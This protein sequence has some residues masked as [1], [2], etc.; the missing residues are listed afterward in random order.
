MDI[1]IKNVQAKR[2]ESGYGFGSEALVNP[3]LFI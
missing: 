1:Q 2:K 3:P